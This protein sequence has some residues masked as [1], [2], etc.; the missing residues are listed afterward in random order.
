MASPPYPHTLPH[1]S[2]PHFPPDLS[3]RGFFAG[4]GWDVLGVIVLQAAGGMIVATV[5]KYADNVLKVRS[6]LTFPPSTLAP[7]KP[8][9]SPLQPPAP[10]EGFRHEL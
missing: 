8:L 6:L 4:Y 9:P 10:P 5:V 7:L 3:T 1:V 2:N